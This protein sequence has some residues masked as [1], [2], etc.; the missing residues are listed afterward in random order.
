[1]TTKLRS[2]FTE[3]LLKAFK[4]LIKLTELA[5]RCTYPNPP[6]VEVVNLG[7][8]PSIANNVCNY[9]LASSSCSLFF[10]LSY[11]RPRPASLVKKY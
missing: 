1:M 9:R 6:K 3:A 8:S 5:V 4:Q 2:Y 11:L 10:F 7:E